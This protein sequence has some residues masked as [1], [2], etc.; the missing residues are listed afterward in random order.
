MGTCS[1]STNLYEVLE[2][3]PRASQS[4]LRKAYLRRVQQVHPDRLDPDLQPR[5]WARANEE[6]K[7]LNAAYS[8]LS[9]AN[10]RKQY[11]A[12]WARDH[13]P[14]SQSRE[15][16]SGQTQQRRQRNPVFDLSV[17]K[18]G[19]FSF[20][21]LPV[22]VQSI[23]LERQ[24]R[25]SEMHQFK[26]SLKPFRWPAAIFPGALVW[27]A[28]FFLSGGFS[29]RT[30]FL[31]LSFV[32]IS[33][34]VLAACG[35]TA[36]FWIDAWRSPL[37]RYFYM[38]PLYFIFTGVHSVSFW[39]LHTL[40]DFS[41]SHTTDTG[42]TVH[43]RLKFPSHTKRLVISGLALAEQFEH[44]LRLYRDELRTAL[45]SNIAHFHIHN[46]FS[47]VSQL[48]RPHSR[49]R[50]YSIPLVAMLIFICMGV[51][52]LMFIPGFSAHAKSSSQP[53]IS[54]D[55]PGNTSSSLTS[56]YSQPGLSS[57]LY[58]SP[59]RSSFQAKSRATTSRSKPSVQYEPLPLP[60][61]GQVQLFVNRP[62]I[63][64][65]AIHGGTGVNYFIKLISTSSRRTVMS[66]FVRSGT[67]VEVDVP[68]GNYELRYASGETWYGHKHLFGQDTAYSKA[69]ELV[70]VHPVRPHP[71]GPFLDTL[72]C[73]RGK[74]FPCH[75]SVQTSSDIFL[76]QAWGGVRNPTSFRTLEST[77]S[78]GSENAIQ[79]ISFLTDY[80][81]RPRSWLMGRP[82]FSFCQGE[83]GRRSTE[84][85]CRDSPHR[86][87]PQFSMQPVWR[88]EIVGVRP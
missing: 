51:A 71:S 38:T 78:R 87:R 26:L 72:S 58:K 84:G 45:Y 88:I 31:A 66:V 24:S 42:H 46:D 61:T 15:T 44:T 20:S 80:R 75:I 9:N 33:V 60:P 54:V 29:S 43:V 7:R 4:A 52:G 23:L 82:S 10:L 50:T 85:N 55:G 68:L 57:P 17:L 47:S 5:E 16:R 35:I 8:L 73:L 12:D 2:V 74:T 77:E 79:D 32:L 1:S 14:A 25:G 53:S 28:Y 63:A 19:N 69:D 83:K 37:K 62:A 64:P 11:D 6:L 39:P 13:A 21:V 67:T 22:E 36:G 49:L 3:E 65:F 27:F 18:P 86:V 81:P 34:V 70:F 30:G 41:V 76:C 56:R 59:T 40:L 48:S